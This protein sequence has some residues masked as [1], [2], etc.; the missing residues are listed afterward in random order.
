MYYQ[1]P[2]SYHNN[3]ISSDPCSATKARTAALQSKLL[4]ASLTDAWSPSRGNSASL[5]KLRYLPYYNI[6]ADK[7]RRIGYSINNNPRTNLCRTSQLYNDTKE[8]SNKVTYS[9]TNTADVVTEQTR[10]FNFRG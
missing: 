9:K 3:E 6:L 1:P 7:D 2:R 8:K 10:R 4:D 5:L